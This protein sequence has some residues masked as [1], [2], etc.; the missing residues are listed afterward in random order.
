MKCTRRWWSAVVAMVAAVASLGATSVPSGA[1]STTREVHI[2]AL[3]SLTGDGA[4]LG[5]T[6]KAA[7]EIAA[8]RW[9]ATPGQ[10]VKVL[11]DIENT[12]LE[13]DKALAGL[14]RLADKDVPIVIGPQSSSEV[15]RHRGH[16]R[17]PMSPRRVAGEYRVV[18]CPAGRQRL[19]LRPDGP[20]RRPRERGSHEE[21]RRDNDRPD[22]AKRPRQHR[23][24]GV[25]TRR[26]HRLG[27]D[28]H[29]RGRL[30]ARHDRLRVILGIHGEAA[31]SAARIEFENYNR[32]VPTNP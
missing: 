10:G 14:T 16:G 5:T 12:N 4:T 15:T 7:L 23:A 11:L 3:L 2:G 21:E 6:T 28:G 17:G 8:K 25:G 26:R 27:H 31:A 1:G 30:R 13:P 29:G 19:P 20:C 24:L 22:V 18:S 9:N 32:R